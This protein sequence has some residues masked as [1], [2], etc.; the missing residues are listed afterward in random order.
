MTIENVFDQALTEWKLKSVNQSFVGTIGQLYFL[1]MGSGTITEQSAKAFQKSIY[2]GDDTVHVV[3]ADKVR[4]EIRQRIIQSEHRGFIRPWYAEVGLWA[5][6]T[7]ILKAMPEEDIDFILRASLLSEGAKESDTLF[8]DIRKTLL[9][10]LDPAVPKLEDGT[11]NEVEFAFLRRTL[12]EH[13]RPIIELYAC[14]KGMIKLLFPLNSDEIKPLVRFLFD[15]LTVDKFFRRRFIPP[16]PDASTEEEQ[17]PLVGEFHSLTRTSS[18]FVIKFLA[19]GDEEFYQRRVLLLWLFALFSENP[20]AREYLTRRKMGCIPELDAWA[21]RNGEGDRIA[22]YVE[23]IRL[24]VEFN[25]VRNISRGF[26]QSIRT[27]YATRLTFG[28]YATELYHLLALRESSLL[29]FENQLYPIPVEGGDMAEE[30]LIHQIG[31]AAIESELSKLSST[32]PSPRGTINAKMI[33]VKRVANL[34]KAVAPLPLQ[35]E[36]LTGFAKIGEFFHSEP[37]KR[38]LIVKEMARIHEVLTPRAEKHF[39]EMKQRIDEEAAESGQYKEELA[40]TLETPQML[41]KQFGNESMRFVRSESLNLPNVSQTSAMFVLMMS[42]KSSEL[43]F[44]DSSTS[45]IRRKQV[46]KSIYEDFF[47]PQVELINYAKN[48]LRITEESTKTDIVPEAD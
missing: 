5:E 20:G 30:T 32:V 37:P 23:L 26:W 38:D 43:L 9:E 4:E 42:M 3:R 46:T 22:G 29:P 25:K 28:D 47:V 36:I 24:A 11:V 8:V 6:R 15:S 48:R 2:E 10:K 41:V 19:E 14:L 17:R 45:A 27:E 13:A 31:L 16:K 39:S 34:R 12:E 7:T 33:L 1:R 44:D 35:S 40:A 18:N 21:T